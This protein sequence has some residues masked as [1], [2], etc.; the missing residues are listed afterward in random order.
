MVS[1]PSC[2]RFDS[3]H[4]RNIAGVNQQRWLEESGQWLE[5]VDRNHQVLASGKPVLQKITT[6]TTS[7]TNVHPDLIS[8][9]THYLLFH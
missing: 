1:G 5:N 7:C 9:F 6:L 3:L 4:S 2:P 8:P